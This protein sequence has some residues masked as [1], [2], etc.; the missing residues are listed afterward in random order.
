[1][2]SVAWVLTWGPAGEEFFLLH[3]S[4]KRESRCFYRVV[5]LTLSFCYPLYI[6]DSF[7]K[8]YIPFFD[9]EIVCQ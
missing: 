6:R 9:L 2:Q 8:V 5:L 4:K 1:M 3:R 7:N